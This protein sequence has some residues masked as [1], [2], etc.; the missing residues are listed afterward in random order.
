MKRSL[1][2]LGLSSKIIDFT[3]I[4]EGFSNLEI[5]ASDGLIY[6]NSVLLSDKSEVFKVYIDEVRSG[7]I[8][9][10]TLDTKI[11]H[12]NQIFNILYGNADDITYAVEFT[13]DLLDI[14]IKFKFNSV[15]K[16][17]CDYIIKNIVRFNDTS[18]ITTKLIN[19]VFKY[20]LVDIKNVMKSGNI[21]NFNLIYTST[22]DFRCIAFLKDFET[23]YSIISASKVLPDEIVRLI[24]NFIFIRY[25]DD[26]RLIKLVDSCTDLNL[27]KEKLLI[28]LKAANSDAADSDA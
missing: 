28:M 8:I 2:S 4:K 22:V 14:A 21:F 15:I 17:I 16:Y 13:F 9:R 24:S 23:I 1:D 19:Y 11:L 10:L 26:V 6:F 12:L 20:N 3:V 25:R 18:E 27:S 7:N 5:K